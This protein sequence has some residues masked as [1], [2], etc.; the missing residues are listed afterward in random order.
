[1]AGVVCSNVSGGSVKVSRFAN[2]DNGI[3]VSVVGNPRGK[4]E[5]CRAYFFIT[6]HTVW[7]MQ[8]NLSRP[9]ERHPSLYVS[10]YLVFN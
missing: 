10:G 3:G 9:L 7:A 5:T 8:P 4:Y 6:S 1:M 2:L